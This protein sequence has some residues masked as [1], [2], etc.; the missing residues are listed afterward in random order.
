MG[1]RRV[2]DAVRTAATF[3]RSEP[4]R[5]A[6]RLKA[7][8]VRTWLVQ[9][10]LGIALVL[11][12]LLWIAEL[13]PAVGRS[14]TRSTQGVTATTQAPVTAINKGSEAPGSSRPPTAPH[15]SSPS[16]ATD[17]W[18]SRH[19]EFVGLI[20]IPVVL[21]IL[22]TWI[23]V[24]TRQMRNIAREDLNRSRQADQRAHEESDSFRL[25]ELEETIRVQARRIGYLCGDLE[26]RRV[27]LNDLRRDAGVWPTR[28]F[29]CGAAP[30]SGRKQ[31]Y[32][33][34]ERQANIFMTDVQLA[35]QATVD[36]KTTVE[37]LPERR[38][39]FGDDLA[40]QVRAV[41]EY[42]LRITEDEAHILMGEVYETLDRMA[43]HVVDLGRL[44]GLDRPGP[45]P[46]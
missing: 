16:P 26:T 27:R 22:T 42:L 31:L 33:D 14:L 17:S 7:L 10:L 9:P 6:A 12:S 25:A 4:E 24:L 37:Q 35:L 1:R 45:G 18:W 40:R 5:C 44:L 30:F 19:K 38:R 15:S 2:L 21:L 43:P 36:F 41:E 32:E 11:V 13:S 3:D 39:S 8:G 29:R 28:A 46:G 34:Y 20:V 23:F